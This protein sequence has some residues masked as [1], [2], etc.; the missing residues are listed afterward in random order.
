MNKPR[1][2]EHCDECGG[3]NPPW[4]VDSNTWHRHVP[5]DNGNG[6]E[7]FAWTVLCPYCFAARVGRAAGREHDADA[8]AAVNSTIT[9]LK[10]ILSDVEERRRQRTA[11]VR[12]QAARRPP[13]QQ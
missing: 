1:N 11:R 10:K 5:E 9:V 4:H 12:A 13:A 3:P 2:G 7:G 8:D 6:G